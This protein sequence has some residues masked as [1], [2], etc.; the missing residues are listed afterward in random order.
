MVV[1][2]KKD[3]KW[4]VCVDY[5]NLNDVCLKDSF[6]LPRVDQ[7]V[8]STTE[9]GMFSFLDAFSRYHQ[10]LM[11]QSNEE[12]ITFV[13]LHGLYYYKVIPFGLKNA[14]ATYQRLITKIF[15]PLIGWTVEIYIDDIVVKRKTRAE[16][17]Q[18]LEETFRLMRGYNMKLNPTKCAFGVSTGKFLRFMVTQKEIE[19]NLA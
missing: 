10:I 9:H 13:T 19:I 18:H 5:T 12:K 7:I 4:R 1:V 6:L 11:F 3:G 15:K 8:N 17:V 14:N 2:P 16:H